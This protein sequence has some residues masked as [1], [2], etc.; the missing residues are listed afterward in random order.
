MGDLVKNLEFGISKAFETEKFSALLEKAAKENS[1]QSKFTKKISFAPSGLGY[2]SG[3][4]PRYWYY[5]FNGAFFNY[6]DTTAQSIQNM[7]NGTAAGE[8]IANLLD[9]AGILVEAERP[10]RHEDPPI[11][12]FI[13]AVVEW[14]GQHMIAEVKTTKESTWNYRFTNMKVPGYQ[15]IQLLIYMRVENLDKGF[16]LVENKNTHEFMILPVKMTDEYSEL[17]DRLFDWMRT[18][19]K[20]ALEGELPTRPFTMKS[21]EC[22]SCPVWDTCWSGVASNKEKGKPGDPAPGTITL[23]VLEIPK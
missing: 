2:G 14:Q 12:G 13:D 8:R 22:K 9:Q 1:R 7:N 23:P 3:T 10:V 11:G 21:K 18:I 19:H 17:V 4:C 16:F 20:N 5:A 15:L 6:D